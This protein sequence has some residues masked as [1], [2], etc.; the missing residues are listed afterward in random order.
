MSLLPICNIQLWSPD[1]PAMT[2]K[3]VGQSGNTRKVLLR[4]AVDKMY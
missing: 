4:E 1:F 2:I 3:F